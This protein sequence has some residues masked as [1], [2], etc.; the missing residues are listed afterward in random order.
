ML[1]NL[2]DKVIIL[3]F[4]NLNFILNQYIFTQTYPKIYVLNNNYLILNKIFKN[5]LQ[6][7]ANIS[8]L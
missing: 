6:D 1:I 2:L 8:K 4:L 7:F 3:Y 5:D